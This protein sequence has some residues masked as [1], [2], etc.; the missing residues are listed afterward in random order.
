MT[1]PAV[2]LLFSSIEVSFLA[3]GLHVPKQA[4]ADESQTLLLFAG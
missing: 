3:S 1:T 2:L 4:P